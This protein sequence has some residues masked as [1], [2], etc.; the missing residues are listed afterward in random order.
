MKPIATQFMAN[1]KARAE[2]ARAEA[3]RIYTEDQLETAYQAAQAG[4]HQPYPAAAYWLEKEQAAWQE[5]S[6]IILIAGRIARDKRIGQM[7]LFE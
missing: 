1:A 2:A 3:E 7:S 4:T 5:Y 6:A